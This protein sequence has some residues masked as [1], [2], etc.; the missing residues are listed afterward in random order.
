MRRNVR[1]CFGTC[2]SDASP[3]YHRSV[4][5]D[6]HKRWIFTIALAIVGCRDSESSGKTVGELGNGEF[7]YRCVN[8]NDG[9]CEG[10]TVL[11]PE[12]ILLDG[13]F[14]MDYVLHESDAVD[15]DDF[16]TFVYVESASQ[17]F[18]AGQGHYRADRLGRAALLAREDE[19]IIDIIHLDIVQATGIDVRDALGE[20]VTG[21]VQVVR[22]STVT[23]DAYA[24]TMGCSPVGGGGTV[25]AMSSDPSVATVLA[26]DRIVIH[27]EEVGLTSITISTAGYEQVVEVE[28]LQGPPRRKKPGEDDD[29][30]A[31]STSDDGTSEG[32]TTDDGGTSDGSSSGS[33][34]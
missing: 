18:F 31:E 2:C 19:Q 22:S 4:W 30:P 15:D 10:T 33:E 3:R 28:V 21:R 5:I 25:A 7:L 1:R 34:G 11:F 12:C 14:E 32:D 9:A 16:D 20:A 17:D 23:L 8:P 26:D 24:E 13:E 29:G 27:G 6:L